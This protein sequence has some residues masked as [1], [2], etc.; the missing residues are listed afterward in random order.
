MKEHE[1]TMSATL[2]QSRT[3]QLRAAAEHAPEESREDVDRLL[4]VFYRHTA[5]E[6]LLAR[7][8][9]DLLGAALAERDLARRR[10]VGTANVDVTNPTVESQGWSSGHT[11]VQ[12]VTDDMPFLVDSVTAALDSLGRTVHLV[13]HPQLVV[14]RDAIGA[15]EEIYADDTGRGRVRRRHRVVDAPR[16]RPRGLG[17]GRARRSPPSCAPSSATSATPSRTGAR[18]ASECS[19]IAASS[20]ARQPARRR[21]AP[22]RSA[23]R[24]GFLEWLAANHFTFLGYREYTLARRAAARTCSRRCSGTGLGHAAL[25]PAARPSRSP[26]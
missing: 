19:S 22:R 2:E 21:S 7:E 11:I 23:P 24:P 14:R 4:H 5:T 25:R 15:L 8:P 20:L 6:D 9:E 16:G 13:V 1:P 26:G 12:V 17:G 3:Q 18:C 10:A